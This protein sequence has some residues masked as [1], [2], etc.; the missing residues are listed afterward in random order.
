MYKNGQLLT[1][2]TQFTDHIELD[3]P[4]QIYRNNLHDDIGFVQDITSLYVKVNDTFY[5]RDQFHFISRPG[6]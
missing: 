3:V 2:D 5:R 4:I 6:Y 1:E